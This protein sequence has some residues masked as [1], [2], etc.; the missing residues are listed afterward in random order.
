MAFV[1]HGEKMS[2]F[3]IIAM[4]LSFAGVAIVAYAQGEIDEQKAAKM[5]DDE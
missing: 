3:E 5:T 2:V 1:A 4:I